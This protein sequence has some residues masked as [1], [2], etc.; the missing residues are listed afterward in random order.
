MV[1]CRHKDLCLHHPHEVVL[2]VEFNWQNA[3]QANPQGMCVFFYPV[4]GGRPVRYDFKGTAGGEI[5]LTVGQY[6]VVCYNN[7]T[8]AILFSYSDD[9]AKH[10]AYTREGGL[11]EPVYGSA[12]APRIMASGSEEERIVITPE[13]LWGCATFDVEITDT[14][15]SYTCIPYSSEIENYVYVTREEHII[16]LYPTDYICHYSYE[17][18][19]VSNIKYASQM[20]ASISGMAGGVTFA[21]GEVYKESVTLPLPA[22]IMQESATVYG[23]F[24]TFGHSLSN[25]DPH[26]MLLFV[27]MNNGDKFYFGEGSEKFD[28]TSQ[29]HN[30]PNPKRVH[31]IIEGLDLPKPIMNGGGYKPSV[32]D[33]EIVWDD[34]N[35]GT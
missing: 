34:I 35:M 15:I 24:L 28:V 10:N 17:I 22:T 29:I 26:K 12:A 2:K 4:E 33:W 9:F 16:T 14:G 30:A 11:F 21:T 27:W 32:D 3:P 8:E 18:R 7:D 1:G 6:N 13:M 20:C 19:D 23:E 25:P 31:L 5:E